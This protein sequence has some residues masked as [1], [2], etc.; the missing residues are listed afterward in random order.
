MAHFETYAR[1]AILPLPETVGYLQAPPLLLPLLASDWNLDPDTSITGRYIEGLVGEIQAVPIPQLQ[2]TY[3]AGTAGRSGRAFTAVSGA[4]KDDFVDPTHDLY[5]LLMPDCSPEIAFDIRSADITS[6]IQAA[7]IVIWRGVPPAADSGARAPGGYT[8]YIELAY[9]ASDSTGC[10]IALEWGQ[11]I[12]L[13]TT[14]NNGA[15]WKPASIARNLGLLERYL[16]G[17][18]G[19]VR[20]R[21]LPDSATGTLNIEIGDEAFLSYT[22]PGGVLPAPGR[23]RVSGKCGAVRF[24]Y[25]PLRWKQLSAEGTAHAGREHPNSAAAF[26][27]GGGVGSAAAGQTTTGTATADGTD[28]Q[29]RLAA[30]AGDAGDGNGSTEPPRVAGACIVVPAVW[31]DTVGLLP[32][33]IGAVD[34]PVQH[35]EELQRFDDVSRTLTSAAVVTADNSYARFAGSVGVRAIALSVSVGGAFVP[36]FQGIAGG[37][38]QGIALSTRNGV[39]T[40]RLQCRGLEARMQHAA[41]QRRIYDGWCLWSAVR[42]ECELGNVRSDF[43][44]TLPL[45]IPPGATAEAPYGPAA[46]DC[47][48]PVLSAGTGLLPR[49]DFSPEV[50]PWQALEILV[51]EQAALLPGSGALAPY[52]CGF[53]VTGQFRFEPLDTSALVPVMSYSDEDPTGIGQIVGELIVLNS[54]AQMRSDIA[55]EGV[56]AVTGAAFG[57]QV[58]LPDSV[59]LTVGMHYPWLERSTR[60]APSQDGSLPMRVQ[61][62][63]ATASLPSQIVQFR[64]GFLPGVFAGQKILVSERKSLGGTAEFLITELRS[65]YGGTG[66]G[67]ARECLSE[68]TARRI[69][70]V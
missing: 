17:H 48:Y 18:G 32:D 69:S 16:A 60:L 61:A 42:C 57:V 15:T 70:T 28:Y 25:L 27:V 30:S 40:L 45:Y 41:A 7:D 68:I 56:D 26:L 34:L 49:Y 31:T 19:Q 8:A 29:W 12:R 14:T 55:F 67:G 21:I 66:A 1:A 4:W 24:C 23:I 2:D 37:V 50:S 6:S 5:C 36:R 22:A 10:R 63:V 35:V 47:P 52:F 20:L 9:N 51:R 38:S 62:A 3:L 64:A 39:S 13:D 11:P 59:R 46:A 43:L 54:A 44:Q 33:P 58:P 53:D 65:R